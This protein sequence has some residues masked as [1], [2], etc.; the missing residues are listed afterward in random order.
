M[1]FALVDSCD[2][3]TC[4]EAALF[5]THQKTRSARTQRGQSGLACGL[6]LS[7]FSACNA[8][9]AAWREVA[10]V[11]GPDADSAEAC[12]PS[13][14]RINGWVVAL[15][16]LVDRRHMADAD[17]NRISKVGECRCAR[18]RHGRREAFTGDDESH[19]Q[20]C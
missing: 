17:R 16:R 1:S 6:A 5:L 4:V 15:Q 11:S 20:R 8:S 13:A 18:V 9:I 14:T 19:H 2:G 12:L 3:R 10:T 7:G